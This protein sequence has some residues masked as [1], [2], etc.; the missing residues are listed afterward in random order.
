MTHSEKYEIRWFWYHLKG[1]SKPDDVT[2]AVL[3]K[4][5]DHGSQVYDYSR[6]LSEKVHVLYEGIQTKVTWQDF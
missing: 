5:T 2:Y 3:I 6:K 1:Y 4:P